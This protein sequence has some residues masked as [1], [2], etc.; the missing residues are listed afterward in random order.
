[1]LSVLYKDT[2]VGLPA[3]L[4]WRT[5]KTLGLRLVISL[6]EQLFGTIEL[7]RTSGTAFIIVVKEKE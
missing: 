5:G 4:D 3:D 1:M 6:V 7:D 2:G